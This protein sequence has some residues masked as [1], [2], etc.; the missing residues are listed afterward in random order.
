MKRFS[1]QFGKIAVNSLLAIAMTSP[2]FSLLLPFQTVAYANNQKKTNANNQKNTNPKADELYIQAYTQLF[3]GQLVKAADN[4][5]KFLAIYELENTKQ[6]RPSMKDSEQ[7]SSG[8]KKII[9]QVEEVLFNIYFTL[10]ANDRLEKIANKQFERSNSLLPNLNS[11]GINNLSINNPKQNFFD[12]IINWLFALNYRDYRISKYMEK[13]LTLAR[14]QQKS[15]DGYDLTTELNALTLLGLNKYHTEDYS[16]SIFYLEQALKKIHDEKELIMLDLKKMKARKFTLFKVVSPIPSSMSADDYFATKCSTFKS[17]LDTYKSCLREIVTFFRLEQNF[18][19]SNFKYLDAKT[20]SEIK[21]FRKELAELSEFK[22]KLLLLVQRTAS[23]NISQEALTLQAS[24]LALLNTSLDILPFENENGLLQSILFQLESSPLIMTGFNSIKEENIHKVYKSIETQI[25]STDLYTWYY[26]YLGEAYYKQ[27]NYTKAKEYLQNVLTKAKKSNLKITEVY[28]LLSLSKLYIALGEYSNAVIYSQEALKKIEGSNVSKKIKVEAL[29]ALGYA[30]FKIGKIQ[31]A[32]KIVVQSLDAIENIFNEN[33]FFNKSSGLDELDVLLVKPSLFTSELSNNVEL[34]NLQS[35]ITNTLQQ[36]YVRENKF[37]LALLASEKG[38]GRAFFNFTRKIEK[39]KLLKPLFAYKILSEL[40]NDNTQFLKKLREGDFVKKIAEVEE[41]FKP[42]LSPPSQQKIKQI[43]Q[44]QKATLVEYSIVDDSKIFI[45]VIKP[46]GEITFHQVDLKA[47]KNNKQFAS[48][49]ELVPRI[50]EAIKVR[51]DGTRGRLAFAPGDRVRFKDDPPNSE[52]YEIVSIDTKN[53]ILTVKHPDFAANVTIPRSIKDVEDKSQTSLQLLHELLIQP[54]ENELPSNPD[55]RIVFIPHKELFLVPF[56]ALQDKTGK[57]LIEKHT[58]L[59]APSIQ[60]LQ[61][62]H[63]QR[64]RIPASIKNVLVVGNPTPNKVGSL[65][66]A[67]QEANTIA[68]LLNTKAVVGNNA[69]KS[70]ILD[71]LPQARI[72]HLAAHGILDE[73]RGLGSA[74]ALAPSSW[75]DGLLRAEEIM[76]INLN[77]EL[78]VLSACD[79]ARGDITGDGIVGL[80]RSLIAA[81][82]PSVIVSLWKVPDNTTAPL[83]AEFYR[84]WQRNPDKAIALRQ[85]MLTTMKQYPNPVDW[86]AFTLIGE[87]R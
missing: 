40:T 73:N 62:T 22:Y 30:N 85:A 24:S 75:D 59:T 79:T 35:N 46:T 15:E 49:S 55:A 83:M 32:E 10:E 12:S 74:I 4:F 76:L 70:N 56:P 48:I 11:L 50:R 26:F 16:K 61:L 68:K 78:A 84:N 60:T 5:E 77:A 86:A 3:N 47:Q 28:S 1:K 19:D 57:Y 82:V 54:I 7:K 17:N 87:A 18:E 64:Q 51:A 25:K 65:P 63:Y 14:Q 69:D 52:P 67:E 27:G 21:K 72:I 42:I 58:I 8:V 66:Y 13:S 44:T 38:K 53:G 45:W 23:L 43:A 34:F 20:I 81:G 80:S 6:I 36:I 71:K 39:S 29:H 33:I 31:E 37:Y 2:I 9:E 41:I